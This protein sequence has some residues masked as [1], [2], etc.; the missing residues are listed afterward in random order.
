MSDNEIDLDKA[1]AIDGAVKSA[2]GFGKLLE[3]MTD[4][5]NSINGELRKVVC[6]ASGDRCHACDHYYG[7][8][9]SCKFKSP[10]P[11]GN[12]SEPIQDEI[13]RAINHAAHANGAIVVDVD[14][15]ERC[16]AAL[17]ANNGEEKC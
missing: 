17:P 10:T 8:A 11:S 6:H 2:G 5:P 12:A 16:L 9:E 7:R 15:L 1:K 14:F 4:Q 13:H 3:P